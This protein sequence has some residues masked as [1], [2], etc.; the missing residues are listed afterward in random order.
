LEK[1]YFSSHK[2]PKQKLTCFWSQGILGVNVDGNVTPHASKIE[3]LII[4]GWTFLMIWDNFA[5]E[6]K[7]KLSFMPKISAKVLIL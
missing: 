4:R 2:L 7:L 3:S 1:I 6:H 5:R